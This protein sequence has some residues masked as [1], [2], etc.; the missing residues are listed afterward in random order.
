[1]VIMAREELRALMGIQSEPVLTRVYRW[2]D[3]HPQYDVGHLDRMA[4]IDSLCAAQP[5]LHIAGSSYRGVGLPDCI[6]GGQ[7][8]VESI[9]RR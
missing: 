9:L 4:E 7:L 5:G 8:A 2:R 1:M 3:A 6:H